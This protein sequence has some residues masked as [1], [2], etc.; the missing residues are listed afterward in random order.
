MPRVL[1]PGPG[2]LTPLM[3][4]LHFSLPP[5]RFPLCH[6]TVLL[7]ESENLLFPTKSIIYLAPTTVPFTKI[8]PVAEEGKLV[9]PSLLYPQAYSPNALQT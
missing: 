8:T 5:S 4:P 7:W 2:E 1:G 9:L 3:A 6:S